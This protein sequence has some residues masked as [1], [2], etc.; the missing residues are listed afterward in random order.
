M[1]VTVAVV[2][3]VLI[4][5]SFSRRLV[6]LVI[7]CLVDNGPIGWVMVANSSLVYA[8]FN[9]LTFVPGGQRRSPNV[10]TLNLVL[11]HL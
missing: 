10:I 11:S 5:L 6:L 8:V 9:T 2:S 3:Y 4:F 1:H 7:H